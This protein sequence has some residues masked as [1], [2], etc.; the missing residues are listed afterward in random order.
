LDQARPAGV[1]CTTSVPWIHAFRKR[2]TCA[3]PA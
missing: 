1:Y 2:C 3:A